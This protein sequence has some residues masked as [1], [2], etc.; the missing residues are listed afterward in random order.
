MASSVSSLSITGAGSSPQASVMRCTAGQCGLDYKLASVWTSGNLTVVAAC[1]H[2]LTAAEARSAHLAH[3]LEVVVVL[4]P[5]APVLR[6]RLL[7]FPCDVLPQ[8]CAAACLH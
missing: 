4:G 5:R 3:P 1:A 2:V 7:G 6:Q 8:T